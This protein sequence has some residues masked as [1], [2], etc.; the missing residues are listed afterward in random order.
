MEISM[1]LYMFNKPKGCVTA[2]S[3]E[4]HK[5]VMDYFPEDIRK[6]C[7]PVGRL[8]K[9]TTGLLLVTDDGKLL[10]SLMSPDKKVAKTYVF[11]AYGVLDETKL[12]SLR[13][14]I[15]IGRGRVELTAPC[16]IEVMCQGTYGEYKD[17]M[18]Q[19]ECEEINHK[20]EFQKVVY[21]RITITQ[22][23][24]HQVKRMLRAAGCYIVMLKRVAIGQ[25]YLDE[26]LALGDYKAVMVENIL[27]K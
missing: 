2:R 9:D 11:W 17:R 1:Q 6:N 20:G 22:G 23:K 13:E 19:D 21:G 4:S 7:F 8:D 18:I 16:E 10:E 27:E 14:G 12:N 25:L 3:D 24:K 26:G 5:T 15:D